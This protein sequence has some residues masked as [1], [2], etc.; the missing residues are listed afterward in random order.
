MKKQKENR[1][2]K[3]KKISTFTGFILGMYLVVSGYL[4]Y[5]LYNLTGI[6][7]LIRYIIISLIVI[8]DLF[9]LIRY[10]LMRKRPKTIKYTILCIVLLVLGGVQF[11]ISYNIGK[12]LGFISNIST[13]EYKT[14]KTSLIALKSSN[15]T[16]V[17]D[18][19]SE[20]KIG[21]VNDEND[22]ENYVL[23]KEIMK[24]D[25]IDESTIKNYDDPI[26]MLYELYEGKINA[27]FVSG[28]YIDI[29]KG[30]QKFEKI[31]EE[32]VEID[33]YSKKMKA[34]E[35]KGTKVSSSK[36]MTEPFTILLLGVDSE[37][38]DISQTTGLGDSIMV[39]TFNPETLNAT[40]LSVPRDTFVQIS[41][42]RNVRSKIT[43]AASGGDQCMIN[44]LQNFLDVN[45]DYYV[46][47]NF[48]GLVKI[49]DAIGGIDVDVPYAF[50]EQNSLRDFGEG[51]LQFVEK[52]WQHLN[53]EQALAFSRNRKTVDY[54]DSYWNQG[55]RSDFERGKHQQQVINAIINKIKNLDSLDK[56]YA[57]LDA[58]G[59][60]M[61]TN[62][63]RDTILSFY[64]ILKRILTYSSDLTSD[65]NLIDM[66]KLYLNGR[67]ALIQDGI[68][69]S[70]NLYEYVPSTESLNAIIDAMKENL[71]LKEI[72]P[73]YSFSFSADEEYEQK[74]IGSDLYGGVASYPT[75]EE[76]EAGEEKKEETTTT[77]PENTCTGENEE[78]GADKVTCVCK[79]GY[80]KISGV[81]TKEE[82]SGHKNECVSEGDGYYWYDSDGNKNPTKYSE[83]TCT[84]TSS[85]EPTTPET[86]ETPTE[87]ETPTDNTEGNE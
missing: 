27:A 77:Q 41:C 63:D 84:N 48:R 44:T 1:P 58:L 19:T 79:S 57:L 24:K 40:V 5:N 46:K 65:N 74:V 56:F 64:N 69:S 71:G 43:H 73:N 47:I 36:G 87:P 28:S 76:T 7:N 31:A 52:G 22:I 75:V 42:Y 12:G 30:M 17:S 3:C 15:I 83:S 6:E 39:I 34:V 59:G 82:D 35:N 51:S 18:I 45:I 21:R 26:T 25:D 68:M 9:I 38:E 14:Y 67:G 62:M 53:G 80:E 13:K 49:V 70:M 16:K 8:F 23:A 81:C 54:C 11:F 4:V 37:E 33:K 61:T 72:E 85:E 55:E 32:A 50:C 10:F 78:L 29:Y 66:Q 60:S 86:P 20:T 2:K